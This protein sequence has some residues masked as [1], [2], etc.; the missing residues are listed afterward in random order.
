V[1]PTECMFTCITKK[2][3]RPLEVFPKSNAC[4]IPKIGEAKVEGDGYAVEVDTGMKPAKPDPPKPIPVPQK[5]EY[6]DTA[7]KEPTKEFRTNAEKACRAGICNP[8]AEKFLKC[9][10]Y[11]DNCIQDCVLSGALDFIEGHKRT[12]LAKV[13]AI[14]KS[15][16]KEPEIKK[17][18][19]VIKE[20]KSMAQDLGLGS[21]KCTDCKNGVCRDGGC[22]CNKGW[23]GRKCDKAL[24]EYAVEGDVFTDKPLTKAAPPTKVPDPPAN[25]IVAQVASGETPKISPTTYAKKEEAP[26]AEPS[27][28]SEVSQPTEGGNEEYQEDQGEGEESYE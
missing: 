24:D 3:C 5:P 27:V 10:P 8:E 13:D 20:I 2:N 4:G 28:S 12:Y 23:I 21:N 16:Q 17:N 9:Q 26:K 18:P 22:F 7:G 11:V 6:P 19:E 1:K 15:M 14:V 25:N